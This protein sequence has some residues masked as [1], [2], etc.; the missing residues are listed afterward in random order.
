MVGE[1]ALDGPSDEPRWRSGMAGVGVPRPPAVIRRTEHL[2]G[3]V[4]LDGE[5]G[6]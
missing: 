4:A 5:E 6:A 2:I 1:E 3:P